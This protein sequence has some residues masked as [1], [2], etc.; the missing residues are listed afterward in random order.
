[1]KF[2]CLLEIRSI[3]GEGP[4]LAAAGQRRLLD[5][6]EEAGD[7]LLRRHHQAESRAAG[8]LGRE[9]IGGMVLRE[10]AG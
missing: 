6:P 3:F 5:R 2:V 10:T 4:I 8:S 1:M 7:L 9:T